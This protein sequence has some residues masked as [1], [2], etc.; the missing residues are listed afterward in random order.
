MASSLPSLS[1][2]S[3]L[4]FSFFVLFCSSVSFFIF[5]SC[6]SVVPSSPFLFPLLVYP[7]FSSSS[8]LSHSSLF[9][10]HIHEFFSDFFPFSL[11]FSY[12]LLFLCCSSSSLVLFLLFATRLLRGLHRVLLLSVYLHCYCSLSSIC[13]G[14]FVYV[15]VYRGRWQLRFHCCLFF[16]LPL[17]FISCLFSLMAY[18][19]IGCWFKLYI[20]CATF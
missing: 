1:L 9:F 19:C 3:S 2:S 15:F 12:I 4:S 13:A 14:A 20:I 10:L 5:T 17:G 16:I 8:F 6:S 7:P 11:F 18:K